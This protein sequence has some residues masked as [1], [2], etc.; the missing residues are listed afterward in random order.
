MTNVEVRDITTISFI[1]CLLKKDG[2]WKIESGLPHEQATW[3]T[4]RV[5]KEDY[6]EVWIVRP[7]GLRR[8]WSFR[9]G[10]IVHVG[11]SVLQFNQWDVKE[12]LAVD[13]DGQVG[14]PSKP[15]VV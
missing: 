13:E 14:K 12:E 9:L 2:W 8:A 6:A 4:Y 3:R 10:A 7:D 11:Q 15:T 1:E 5:F